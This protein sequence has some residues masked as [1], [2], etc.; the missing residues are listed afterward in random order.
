MATNYYVVVV[1][2]FGGSGSELEVCK[3]NKR[4]YITAELHETYYDLIVKRLKTGKIPEEYR[5]HTRKK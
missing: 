1:V 4:K 2:L 5:H 3:E